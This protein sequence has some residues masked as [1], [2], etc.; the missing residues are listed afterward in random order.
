MSCLARSCRN[1]HCLTFA[2]TYPHRRLAYARHVHAHSTTNCRENVC[3]ITY[4][5]VSAWFAKQQLTQINQ[6]VSS[7]KEDD[8]VDVLQAS[9]SQRH[10]ADSS[11]IHN[12]RNHTALSTHNTY[13]QTNQSVLTK[14]VSAGWLLM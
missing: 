8:V 4:L 14:N 3:R 12:R 1:P 11:F 13:H 2:V 6:R 10:P 7:C 5:M 9:V